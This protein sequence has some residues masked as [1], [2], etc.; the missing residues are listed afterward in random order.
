MRTKLGLLAVVAVLAA[1]LSVIAADPPI[2]LQTIPVGRML[3]DVRWIA[4]LTGDDKAVKEL[5]DAIKEKLARRVLRASTW[6]DRSS[7][8]SRSMRRP[9][10]AG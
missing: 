1:P 7:A 3:N 4:K 6:I 8:M 5:D 9:S 10:S 2:V